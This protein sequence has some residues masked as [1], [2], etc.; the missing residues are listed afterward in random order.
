MRVDQ[1]KQTTEDKKENLSNLFNEKYRLKLGE[2]NNT[3][4]T[5]LV[6]CGWYMTEN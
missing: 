5:M 4:G 3:T 6:R 2:I 1:T